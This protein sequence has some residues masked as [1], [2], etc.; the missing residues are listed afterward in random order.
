MEELEEERKKS[1]AGRGSLCELRKPRKTVTP[2]LSY[3]FFPLRTGSHCG[4]RSTAVEAPGVPQRCACIVQFHVLSAT[5]LARSFILHARE[6]VFLSHSR[7]SHGLIV[8]LDGL[9]LQ[10]LI[11]TYSARG[12]AAVFTETGVHGVLDRDRDMW[13]WAPDL[14]RARTGDSTGGRATVDR[15]REWLAL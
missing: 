8:I 12:F 14:R 9:L 3:L 11:T 7:S 6:H 15:G 5:S 10:E 13:H 2:I 4:S 1:R